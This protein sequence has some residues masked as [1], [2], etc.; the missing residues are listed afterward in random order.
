MTFQAVI[1]LFSKSWL[2]LASVSASLHVYF[3]LCATV[4]RSQCSGMVGLKNRLLRRFVHD[5]HSQE[6][7]GRSYRLPMCG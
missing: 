2:C 4:S 5:M 1:H 6:G 7:E 3:D